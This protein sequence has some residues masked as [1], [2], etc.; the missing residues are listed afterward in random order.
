MAELTYWTAR[1]YYK[2]IVADIPEESGGDADTDP[3][4]KGISGG[5]TITPL[6]RDAQNKVLDATAI[7]APTLDPPALVALAPISKRASTTGS[8]S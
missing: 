3:E 7:K 6:L 5:V 1:L 2:A 4:T 8:S